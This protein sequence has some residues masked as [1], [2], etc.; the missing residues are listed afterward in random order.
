MAISHLKL[1]WLSLPV[2]E[3]EQPPFTYFSVLSLVHV[4]LALCKDNRELFNIGGLEHF[5][6]KQYL[7]EYLCSKLFS[8]P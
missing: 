5:C 2:S 4:S 6:L 1:S 8:S 7:G 3:L